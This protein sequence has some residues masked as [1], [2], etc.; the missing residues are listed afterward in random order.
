MFVG[1]VGVSLH[2]QLGRQSFDLDIAVAPAIPEQVLQEKGYLVRRFKNKEA[3]FT[4]RGYKID[5]M[6]REV[7]GIPVDVVVNTARIMPLSGIDVRAASLEVLFVSKFRAADKRGGWD[8]EEIRTLARA[9]YKEIKW[10][11][12]KELT[13]DKVEY[14]NIRMTLDIL[15]NRN[16]RF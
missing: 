9:K 1:A 11:K 14:H 5:I 8:E 15:Y 13:K 7:S 12:L 16:L 3:R 2:T 10:D 6:E 4:P